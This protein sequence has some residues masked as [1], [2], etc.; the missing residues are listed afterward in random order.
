MSKG[1]A[2]V[3]VGHSHWGKT[4]TLNALTEECGGGRGKRS[5]NIKNKK[6]PIKKMS[7]DDEPDRG[8]NLLGFIKKRAA[9][10]TQAIV[11]P[12]CPNFSDERKKET[13]E[14][15]KTLNSFYDIF[16][17]VLKNAYN[18]TRK[19]VPSEIGELERYGVVEEISGKLE[20]EVRAEKFKNFIGKFL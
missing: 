17:L 6:I 16:F 8:E 20:C 7:N 14:I 2:F 1:K 9:S 4:F 12:F 19:I 15:L 11:M 3:V 10:Q 13:K 18:D 5:V